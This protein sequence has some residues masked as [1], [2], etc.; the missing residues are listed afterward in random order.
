M[1]FSIPPQVLPEPNRHRGVLNRLFMLFKEKINS[2][3]EMFC[4]GEF[5]KALVD[6]EAALSTSNQIFHMSVMEEKWVE[7]SIHT[8]I[9]ARVNVAHTKFRLQYLGDAEKHLKMLVK[10]LKIWSGSTNSSAAF[11]EVCLSN[12]EYAEVTYRGFMDEVGKI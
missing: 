3:N 10:T 8:L 9:I 11:R 12:L 6:F 1:W 4:I 2:G 5:D 7:D